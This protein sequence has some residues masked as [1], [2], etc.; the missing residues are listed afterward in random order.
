MELHIGWSPLRARIAIAGGDDGKYEALR[1]RRTVDLP[2]GGI[3][4]RV[5]R[6]RRAAIPFDNYV[7]S[8]EV[9]AGLLLAVAQDSDA[10]ADAFSD[11]CAVEALLRGR[12]DGGDGGS[13]E[14]FFLWGSLR[15]SGVVG[16]GRW[17]LPGAGGCGGR[18]RLDF[19]SE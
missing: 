11:S 13:G 18:S 8:G 19:S 7:V 2:C 12:Q 16:L 1:D 6:A 3:D 14:D 17:R 5:H 10:F 15:I 9:G 4:D